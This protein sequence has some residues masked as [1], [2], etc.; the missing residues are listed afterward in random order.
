MG[1]T[2]PAIVATEVDGKSSAS[3][4]Q[5]SD[6]DLPEGDVTVDVSFSS[7]NYKD[8]L[9]VT[10][11]GRIARSFPMV[12]GIDLAGTISEST[13][14]QW[15]AGDDVICTG[16]GL[17][18][19]HPG[20]YTRRQRVKSS[21]LVSRPEGMSPKQTMAVGTAGLTSMLCVLALEGNGLDPSVDGEVLVTGAGGGVGSVA[22][23]ILSKLG[24]QVAASTGRPETHDFL[25]SLG[26]TTIVGRDELDKPGRPLGKTR[27]A[28]AVDCVGG[29]TLATVLSQTAYRGAVAACGLT[30][31]NDLPC[32]VLPFILRGVSLLGVDSVQCPNEVRAT[33][34]QRLADDLD[35][36]LLDSLTTVEPMSRVPELAE[37]ILAGQT[38][39]RIVIDVSR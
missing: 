24:Y 3:L 6:D 1:N 19:S 29:Q 4:Q 23:A 9:A 32:T 28:A 35:A 7:L 18:E 37:Q 10:G 25:R 8:G 21:W 11:K 38:R 26:A 14:P 17:S 27:W 5:V 30:G 2:Y 31:G 15:R 20:G 36:D 33:A 16:W 22:V 39:G 13:A 12:C 34:W